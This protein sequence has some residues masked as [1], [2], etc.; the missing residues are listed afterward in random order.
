MNDFSQQISKLR[1]KAKLT[2][3]ELAE[4][5]QVPASFISGLQTGHR[6]IGELQ[7]KKIGNAL[8]LADRDLEMFVLKAIDTCSEKVLKDFVAY[9]AELLNLLA[10]QLSH[11]GI[12]PQHIQH[13]V[14][15]EAGAE[16]VLANGN[17]ATL[18][19]QFILA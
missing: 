12:G 16:I 4:L 17:K 8:G 13:C 5:A 15:N 1:Q 18:V 6:K 19:T 3:Q 9:P 2:N 14:I 7:A 11:A 10:R